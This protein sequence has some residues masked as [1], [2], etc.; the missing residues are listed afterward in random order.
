MKSQIWYHSEENA[1]RFPDMKK[2]KLSTKL[3]FIFVLLS[4][5]ALTFQAVINYKTSYKVIQDQVR[6][7]SEKSLQNMQAEIN[8]YVILLV[9]ELNNIYK[10]EEFITD[11][12]ADRN[13]ESMK[14]DYFTLVHDFFINNI[15][16]NRGIVSIY[17]YNTNHECITYFRHADTPKYKYPKDIYESEINYN[18]K[19]VREYIDSDRYSVLISSYYNENRKSN[20]LRF[21]YKI[22]INNRSDLIGYFVCDVDEKIFQEKIAK[23][24]YSGEQ[25]VSLQVPGDRVVMTYGNIQENQEEHLTDIAQ[26]IKNN[27][28]ATAMLEEQKK[29]FFVEQRKYDLIAYSIVP[30]SVFS[31]EKKILM[32]Y[33]TLA[34]LAMV[35][36][37]IISTVIITNYLTK[38]L[39]KLVT[40]M[41]RIKSG[42]RDLLATVESNDE[43]GELSENFNSML[44][45]IE[46]L[47]ENE[48][49]AKILKNQAEYK[50]LQAQINPHFLHNTLDTM[51]GIARMKN[52]PEVSELCIALSHI[53][54]Y[55]I[56]M[57]DSLSSVQKEIAHLTNYLFVMNVRMQNS[58]NVKID[59]CEEHRSILIPR[60]SLQP[61]VENAI[62]HGLKNKR[63]EKLI[64]LYT[65][66]DEKDVIIIVEDNGVGM[67][68]DEINQLLS[69]GENNVLEK[70]TSIGL[71]N[72]HTRLRILFGD[73]Y[74]ISI[75]S[76]IGQGSRILVRVPRILGNEII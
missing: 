27:Q 24:T 55:S 19:K 32:N 17:I 62:N 11:L 69:E 74:G 8:D 1:W 4:L 2:R 76:I 13:V 35:L 16:A 39:E 5:I 3:I 72:I 50:A 18:S 73:K 45:Q 75:E 21:V 30:E 64:H 37:S 53:F 65:L 9:R 57:K 29:V 46:R 66:E 48:Y 60:L 56:G 10:E 26:K 58:L 71:V 52:C 7:S 33:I 42:E 49:G 40:V 6:L 38:P 34:G 25:V 36:L 63:G 44:L 70:E 59:I 68:Q 51:S 43:I 61:I 20:I 47:I 23:Y 54:R 15:S 14:K 67:S 41:K 22:Y 12:S 31:N 28:V